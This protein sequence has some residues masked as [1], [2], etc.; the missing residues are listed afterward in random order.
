MNK[1]ADECDKCGS[2]I[3]DGK[4]DCGTWFNSRYFPSFFKTFE[5]TIEA[6]N[7]ICDQKDDYS[8]LSGDHHSGTCIILFRGDYKKCMKVKDYVNSLAVDEEKPGEC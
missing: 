5:T 3:I 4:C 7:F 6:Y 1:Y 2:K 8:P